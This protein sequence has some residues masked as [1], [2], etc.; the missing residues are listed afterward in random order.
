MLIL[1]GTDRLDKTLMIGQ[2]Q[3]KFQLEVLPDV[4]HMLHEDNP[5]KIAG[6]LVE[7]WKRNERLPI[8][9]K[10]KKVGES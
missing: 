5:E 8:G 7:F 1:A 2:M 4:G 10:V 6:L 9:F 3:G